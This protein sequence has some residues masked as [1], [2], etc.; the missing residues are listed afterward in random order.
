[1][2]TTMT[3][4]ARAMPTPM[5]ALAR[6]H[7]LRRRSVPGRQSLAVPMRCLARTTGRMIMTT[8]ATTTTVALGHARVCSTGRAPVLWRALRGGGE[9]GAGEKGTG[10]TE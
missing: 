5:I 10:G 7:E 9:V 6:R 4:A 3:A 1:M 2:V 8:T